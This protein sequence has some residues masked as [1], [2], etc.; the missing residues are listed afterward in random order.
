MK[1]LLIL[2][3]DK[4]LGETL[5]ERLTKEGYD[6]HWLM[7]VTE[8]RRRINEENFDLIILDV[9]LPDG[10]GFDLAKDLN[11][12]SKKFGETFSAAPFIFVTARATPEDRLKGFELGADEYIQ[13]PFHLKELLL[14]VEHVLKNQKPVRAFEVEGV[15][16]DFSALQIISGDKKEHMNLKESL[17]LKVLI[18]KSPQALSREEILKVVWG[19][20]DHQTL[21][22]V[23]NVIVR[24]RQILG[25]RAG[26]YIK[27]IR[28]VGY[29]WVK[30]N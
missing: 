25:E 13:K 20:N 3:D 1:K 23:D 10:S 29:Q 30:P 15:Q 24:L 14:R 18:E 22:T 2:E 21:R 19:K 17:V 28:G 8:A 27:S 7:S 9:G 16:I 4:S 26:K 11:E 5:K 12:H 6:V